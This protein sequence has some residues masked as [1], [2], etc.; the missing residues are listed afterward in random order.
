MLY[1]SVVT[2]LSATILSC[3]L[4]QS[5]AARTLGGPANLPPNGFSGQQFVDDRGCVFLRAG[6]GGAVNWVPRV[7]ADRSALCGFPPT[8]GAAVAATVEADM[9]PD[10]QAGTA[11]VVIAQP[12]PT[13]RVATAV[14]RNQGLYG[15]PVVGD[16]IPLFP[17]TPPARQMVAAPMV[18]A[19]PVLANVQP[20]YA[21][22]PTG[23]P[24]GAQA[25]CF[26][27]A[28]RLETVVLRSGGTALVCTRGDG[29]LSGWRSPVFAQGATGASLTANM[30]QGA[31][32]ATGYSAPRMANAIP[33][34]PPGYRLAWD[35]D[36]L[37]PLRGVGTAIGQAQQDQVWTRDIPAHLAIAPQ[38]ATGA[39]ARTTVSTMSSPARGGQA[40]VQVGTF[41]QPANATGVKARLTALG[42]PVST[43][44]I[45]RKGRVLQIVFA[46]PFAT[47]TEVQSALATAQSAGFSDAILK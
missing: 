40:Y 29:T 10:P 11:P 3:T 12:A 8:F 9:Q 38:A 23:G 35:D 5:L 4:A 30:M 42:L 13:P 31:T 46:G 16:P 1:R 43:S 20:T 17:M 41:G 45:T 34:P 26:S 21:T 22:A 28:P 47:A 37:N 19:Q 14:Q 6:F 36:R 24:T 33:T 15:K 27:V 39:A 7:K 18:L 25:Q 44:T 2:V 32:L